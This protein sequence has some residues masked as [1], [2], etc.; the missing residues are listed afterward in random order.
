MAAVVL[1][2]TREHEVDRLPGG[3]AAGEA[4]QVLSI[5][6]GHESTAVPD[7]RARHGGRTFECKAVDNPLRETVGTWRYGN[8][9]RD[10]SGPV[11][12]INNLGF[13][14][15]LKNQWCEILARRQ[16]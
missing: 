9:R 5:K 8:E 16:L 2:G 4:G 6:R 13:H 7:Q 15:G 3:S 11:A 12:Q 10:R 14:S 1:Q